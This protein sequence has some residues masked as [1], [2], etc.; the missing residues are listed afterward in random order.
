VISDKRWRGALRGPANAAQAPRDLAR[1]D[2]Q[3]QAKNERGVCSMQ[4][5]KKRLWGEV[6]ACWAL[7]AADHR[8]CSQQYTA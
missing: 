6:N 7:R 3:E 2:L 1:G 8:I 4:N 5:I